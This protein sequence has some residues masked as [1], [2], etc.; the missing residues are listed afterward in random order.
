MT[1][2]RRW[3]LKQI[4][5]VVGVLLGLSVAIPAIVVLLDRDSVKANSDAN[6]S[7]EEASTLYPASIPTV[8]SETDCQKQGQEW[9]D[10]KCWDSDRSPLD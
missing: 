2:Q 6:Q 1:Q 3:K 9:H 10:G 4:L 5:P 7:E 8:Q